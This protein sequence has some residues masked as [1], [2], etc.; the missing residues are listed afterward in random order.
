MHPDYGVKYDFCKLLFINSEHRLMICELNS[1]KYKE[2]IDFRGKSI[3][4]YKSLK[5]GDRFLIANSS[6]EGFEY[7]IFIK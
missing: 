6:H 3:N 2:F 7:K 4:R 5:T 1:A